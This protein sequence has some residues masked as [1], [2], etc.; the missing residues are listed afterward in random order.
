MR[1]LCA[2]W[3]VVCLQCRDALSKA[4]YSKLFDYIVKGVNIA[5]RLKDGGMQ[6]MQVSV[7]DI[8]GFEVS[9]WPPVPGPRIPLL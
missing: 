4:L 5:L 1:A 8:F 7:L 2:D 9:F 3:I 6:T